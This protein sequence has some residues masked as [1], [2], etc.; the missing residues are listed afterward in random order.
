[1]LRPFWLQDYQSHVRQPSPW[2]SGGVTNVTPFATMQ[3][4]RVPVRCHGPQRYTAEGRQAALKQ[5]EADWD[6]RLRRLKHPDFA[7]R[8]DAIMNARGRTKKRPIVG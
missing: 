4:C 6:R 2:N 1:M 3:R 5:L 8:V 7:K